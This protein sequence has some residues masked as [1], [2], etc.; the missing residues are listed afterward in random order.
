MGT[1]KQVA[2]FGGRGMLGT[3]LFEI[4][5]GRGLVPTTYDLPELD[6]R[7]A[8]HLEMALLEADAVVNCAAYTNVDGAES[9]AET[10]YSVNADAVGTLGRLAAG[11]NVPVLHISTDFVFDGKGDRPYKEDDPVG[12]LGVYGASKLKGEQLLAESGCHYC[13]VRVQWTYGTSGNN[14]IKKILERGRNGRPLK[15]VDDQIG[16]PTSTREVALALTDLLLRPEGMPQGLFHFAAAGYASRF[17]VARFVIEN[18]GLDVEVTPCK[19]NEFATPA[20]RPLNSRFDC[21]KISEFL[22]EP[23][24]PWQV[25]LEYY[26]EH[27]EP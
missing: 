19:S 14:F 10:A 16:A 13:T 7:N 18:K 21:R 8:G 9:N 4:L 20:R 1:V 26:L 25:P 3:D 17:E 23:I 27:L 11:R 2:V 24:K 22:A 6:L 5:M 12:P 15:V